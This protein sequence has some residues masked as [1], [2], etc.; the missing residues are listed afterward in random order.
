MKKTLYLAMLLVCLLLST[1]KKE[2]LETDPA[3]IIL[4]KWEVL[5]YG[6]GDNLMAVKILDGFHYFQEDSI[7]L[8]FSY[9]E[10]QYTA[11]SRYWF[12]DTLLCRNTF[13]EIEDHPNGGIEITRTHRYQ[14]Y[15]KNDK[16]RLVD[17]GPSLLDTQILKRKN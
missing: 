6:V 10:N 13:W 3:K 15:G 2:P 16:L 5:E 4:G 11:K 14:F 7:L 12:A 9:E 8:F 17:T 1:C